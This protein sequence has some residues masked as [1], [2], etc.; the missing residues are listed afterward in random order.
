[1]TCVSQITN[2]QFPI[3]TLLS[4]SILIPVYKGSHLLR[5]ALESIF[6]QTIIIKTQAHFNYEIIIGDDNP[7][8]A[9]EEIEKTKHLIASFKNKP[10]TYIKNP[11]NL[12]YPRNLHNLF[13]QAKN[14]IIF[15]FAQDDILAKDALQITHDA[16]FLEDNIGAITRPYFWFEKDIYKPVR[17]V[18]PPDS[19]NHIILSLKDCIP[20]VRNGWHEG[21]LVGRTSSDGIRNNNCEQTIQAIFGSIGQLSG[22]AYKREYIDTPVHKDVFTA[23]MYPFA[24]ILKKHNCVFL[25]DFTVA[26]GIQDSQSRHIAKIYSK[27]PTKEWI[28]MF[29]TVYAGKEYEYIRT[30]CIKHMATHYEGLVQLKNYA[31]P[32]IL[33]REIGIL[34]HYYWHNI[35]IPKF[36]FYVVVTILTPK[37]ILRWLTDTYKR[38]IVSKTIPKIKFEI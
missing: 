30:L 29:N 28:D 6:K 11:K 27:S 35:C 3:T 24:S 20:H 22:L 14:D 32:G 34:L 38:Y 37:P 21:T 18:L 5:A 10:I 4:F 25:K 26:I 16:F 7:P 1:M 8:E 9:K 31:E 2:Y 23:H 17:A 33:E 15:L 13:Q 36:W 12:G 19:N